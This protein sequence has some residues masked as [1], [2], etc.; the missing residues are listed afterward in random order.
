MWYLLFIFL[1]AVVLIPILLRQLRNKAK[2]A[3]ASRFMEPVAADP[4]TSLLRCLNMK[5]LCIL[6]SLFF[7]I[8]AIGIILVAYMPGFPGQL[9]ISLP[10][11][12]VIA[13]VVQYAWP[14]WLKRESNSYYLNDKAAIIKAYTI[15]W[16]FKKTVQIIYLKTDKGIAVLSP[17]TS[18]ETAGIQGNR[19]LRK[20]E[21]AQN[22]EQVLRL[23]KYLQQSGVEKGAFFN[24]ERLVL[25]AGIVFAIIVF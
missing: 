25:L 18:P 1:V 2:L 16:Y 17:I 8:M 11:L 23:E 10:F 20:Q 7:V 14:A 22:T 4:A 5:R 6:L 15:K 24:Y 9:I 12:F 21:T 19:Q 13:L 3:E